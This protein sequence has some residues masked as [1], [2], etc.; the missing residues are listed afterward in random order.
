MFIS[1]VCMCHINY[2]N[3]HTY[4]IVMVANFLHANLCEQQAVKLTFFVL[5]TTQLLT[6]KI[7]N[8]PQHLKTHIIYL[9]CFYASLYP[10]VHDNARLLHMYC[11]FLFMQVC[12]L[13]YM[14]MQDYYTCTVISS[15]VMFLVEEHF[16]W[17]FLRLRYAS[18]I[19]L[20]FTLL[21][22]ALM[23]IKTMINLNIIKIS[24]KR[25]NCAGVSL[26]IMRYI[27]ETKQSGPFLHPSIQ[28]K[29]LAPV[30]VNGFLAW[31]PALWGTLVAGWEK[32]GELVRTSL[33][34]EFHLQFPCGSLST[35]LSDYCQSARM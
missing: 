21:C 6:I 9:S 23:A 11:Y 2:V 14:I 3:V 10:S 7:D 4:A 17:N 30:F 20:D 32:E 28:I 18:Y 15:L 33:E 24:V 19:N 1:V 22:D 29:K 16:A 26:V 34:S 12:T 8:F 13:Q 27:S 31:E 35:E 25:Q 5:W